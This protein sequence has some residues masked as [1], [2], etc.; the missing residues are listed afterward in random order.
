[1]E[2]G[3]VEVSTRSKRK[4]L[5]LLAILTV[6]VLGVG[7]V[8]GYF[9]YF[10]IKHLLS[11]SK[12]ADQQCTTKPA[13]KKVCLKKEHEEMMKYHQKFQSTVE[14]QQLENNLK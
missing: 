2:E 5:I 7:I 11:E 12:D 4:Q 14:E 13:D 6:V 10:G 8:V 3:N 9:D 1:M